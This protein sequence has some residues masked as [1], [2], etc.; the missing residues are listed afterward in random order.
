MKTKISI[1]LALVIL[2]LVPASVL[3]QAQKFT[4]FTGTA[5]GQGTLIT[6]DGSK[7]KINALGVILREDGDAQITIF[8]EM[9]LTAQGK[10][11][12]G[13]DLSKG[14]N[15]KITGGIVS[16]NATGSGKLFLR[17]D[18][19]SIASLSIQAKNAT[20]GKVKVDFVAD[21]NNAAPGGR[22]AAALDCLLIQFLTVKTDSILN[23]V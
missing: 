22:A 23:F 9:Q 5:K 20:G 10:W 21:E 11:T 8:T 2:V 13:S 15:L 14:I 16:G 12:A 7:T 19:K 6:T 1:F 17:P 3:P 18:G 4:S